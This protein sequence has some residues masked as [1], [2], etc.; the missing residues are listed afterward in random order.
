MKQ[1]FILSLAVSSFVWMSC[2]DDG[3]PSRKELQ[4]EISL[5]KT[6]DAK[7]DYL[8]NIL[9][10]MQMSQTREARLRNIEGEES[11]SFKKHQKEVS[12]TE[13]INLE[14][15]DV[16]FEE[17]GYP[18]R[19]ELGQYAAFAPYAVVYHSKYTDVI[20]E[21]HFKYFYGAFKFNE[22][23]EDLYYSYLKL[24]FK[25]VKSVDFEP[26]PFATEAEN[27]KSILQELNIEQ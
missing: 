7:R 13:K 20:R 12:K 25:K 26:N 11:K 22:L 21:E 3:I 17:F 5:L 2:M 27:V 14:K 23:P 4:E 18:S 1:I 19:A 24:Y 9:V 15:I 16:Y 6:L 10:E 8:E